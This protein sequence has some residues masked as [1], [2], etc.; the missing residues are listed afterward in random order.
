MLEG[1]CFG[2]IGERLLVGVLCLDMG[3]GNWKLNGFELDISAFDWERGGVG[4]RCVWAR[5]E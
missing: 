2:E 5:V 1:L 3:I 4:R